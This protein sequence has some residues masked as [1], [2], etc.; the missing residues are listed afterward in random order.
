LTLVSAPAG[1]GKTTAVSEWLSELE[2]R[3]DRPGVGWLS[4]DDADNDPARFLAHLRAALAAAGLNVH[5]PCLALS[6]GAPVAAAM[7]R[8]VND[9]ALAGRQEPEGHRVV[10]LA[11]YHAVDV[12]DIHSALEFLLNHLPDGLHLVIA[13]RSDSPLPLARLRARGQ[14]IELRAADLRFT[15]SEVQ[16]YLELESS[17]EAVRPRG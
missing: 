5:D 8:L 14:L 15:L 12:A 17:R 2:Q 7:T 4:L 11:D 3:P 16:E 6:S 13:T 10:V 1:F 9:L